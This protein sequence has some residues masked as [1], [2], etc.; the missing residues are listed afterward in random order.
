M[1]D[2]TRSLA[3]GAL[4]D[5]VLRFFANDAEESTVDVAKS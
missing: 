5:T 1:F 3:A 2:S 4:V